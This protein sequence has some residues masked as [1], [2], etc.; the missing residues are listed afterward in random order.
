MT[1]N[2]NEIV[3]LKQKVRKQ[4]EIV[5]E[6]ISSSKALESSKNKEE[7]TMIYVMSEEK[8]LNSAPVNT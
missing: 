8:L 4:R 7:K 6:L 3:S 1:L 5:N 2:K